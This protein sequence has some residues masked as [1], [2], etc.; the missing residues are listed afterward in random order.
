MIRVQ[1]QPAEAEL[2]LLTKIDSRVVYFKL[3]DQCRVAVPGKVG[4][5]YAVCS[6]TAS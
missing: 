5:M 4:S 3:S 6:N 1:L 2:V